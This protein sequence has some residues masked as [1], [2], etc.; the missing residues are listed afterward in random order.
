MH[1]PPDH[2]DPRFSALPVA[3]KKRRLADRLSLSASSSLYEFTNNS[4]QLA[5]TRA[6]RDVKTL[7][8]IACVCK[9]CNFCPNISHNLSRWVIVE[10]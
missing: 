10:V 8:A 1:M 9:S 6:F 7:P 4:Q 2:A 5:L 3:G